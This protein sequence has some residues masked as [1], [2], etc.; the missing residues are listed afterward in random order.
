MCFSAD[1]FVSIDRGRDKIIFHRQALWHCEPCWQML[2]ARSGQQNKR[3]GAHHAR[4]RLLQAPLD[5]SHREGFL[6]EN[7]AIRIGE[8]AVPRPPP[9]PQRPNLPNS[10]LYLQCIV[11]CLRHCLISFR[12]L[13]LS[14][15]PLGGS[16]PNG[17][18][19]AHSSRGDAVA[20]W[21]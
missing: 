17:C 18:H 9:P 10:I 5:I 20:T 19:R 2:C 21:F 8:L 6:D 1:R 15:W 12:G 14:S 11:R 13:S 3:I 4:A 7:A 16:T